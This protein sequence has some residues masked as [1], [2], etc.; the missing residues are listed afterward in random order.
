MFRLT[1][2][3][4]LSLVSQHNYYPTYR[5]DDPF[6]PGATVLPGL[7]QQLDVL[8]QDEGPRE[9]AKLLFAKASLHL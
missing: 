4:A 5:F 1:C 9:K 2:F 8:R 7:A 3:L 6:L